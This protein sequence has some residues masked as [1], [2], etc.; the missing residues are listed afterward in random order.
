MAYI[1]TLSYFG[2]LMQLVLSLLVISIAGLFYD[3]VGPAATGAAVARAAIDAD[4]RVPKQARELVGVRPFMQ[5]EA[6]AANDSIFAVWDI[7]GRDFRFQ[8][9][10]G[11]M[12]V[13]SGKLGA[14]DEMPT[15]PME[16]WFIHAPLNGNEELNIGVEPL[17]AMAVNGQ[18]GFTM[19][20]STERT[21]KPTIYGLCT[22]E[23]AAVAAAGTLTDVGDLRVDN[24]LRMHE[25]CGIASPGEEVVTADEELAGYFTFRCTGWEGQQE[26]RFFHAPLHCIEADS[27]LKKIMSIMRLPFD[28]PFKSKQATVSGEHYNYDAF[29][30]AGELAYGIRWIGT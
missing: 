23:I 15:T 20:Y 24:G 30:A 14:I 29:D 3:T 7:I 17:S 12:P 25:L 18:A 6:P 19:I 4:Y 10:E 1:V 9:C 8:P 27:G 21:G 11:F 13:G 26:T 28:A 16:T 5:A 2:L 22:R